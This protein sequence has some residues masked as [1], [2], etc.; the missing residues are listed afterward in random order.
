MKRTVK[1]IISFVAILCISTNL[2]YSQVENSLFNS[3]TVLDGKPLNSI[4]FF[5][6]LENTKSLSLT[7]ESKI[8][9]GSVVIIVKDPNKKEKGSFIINAEDKSADK[10]AY[11]IS[12]NVDT[13]KSSSETPKMT[14]PAHL[15]VGTAIINKTINLPIKG[16]W[17]IGIES[18]KAKGN[19]SIKTAINH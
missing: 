1:L 10:V 6:I 11:A 13:T 8:E 9:K 14:F 5:K 12:V 7:I 3:N 17:T 2:I 19:V 4:K 18:T 15:D 16:K